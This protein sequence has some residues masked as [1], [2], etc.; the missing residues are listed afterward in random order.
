[1]GQNFLPCDREQQLLMP[2]SLREWLPEGHLAWFVLDAVEELDLAAFY[3]GYRLDGHG[4]AALDPQMMVALVLYAYAVGERSARG[5]ER[6]CREDVAFRVIAANQTPDH[7]TVARFRVRHEQALG[8][9]FGSVLALCAR[10]GLVRAG[11]VALDGTKIAANA[12]GQASMDY[13]QIAREIVEE[14]A[15]V[16]REEDERFGAARG[17]ELP[18]E[19][20]DPATRK[21]RLRQAKRELEAEWEA[22][23]EAAEA[24]NQRCQEHAEARAAGRAKSGRPPLPRPLPERPGGRVNVTDPDSRPVKTHRGFIQ[25]YN[26][27]AAATEDQIVVAAEVM[28]GGTD[29]GLL[30]PMAARIAEELEQA[31]IDEPIGTLLADAGYWNREQIQALRQAGTDT[32]VTPD[33]RKRQRP[34]KQPLVREL[35]A[36]LETDEGRAL[37]RKRAQTIEPVFGQTKTNRRIDRFQRRGLAACRSEWRLIT[38]THNLLK[39][40]RYGAA[41]ATA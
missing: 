24:H 36:R 17:D 25:G 41:P 27:Q 28:I 13:E 10:A 9:L 20:A 11:T 22:E 35:R 4:R 5:V 2:P 29:Q 15:R 38:A 19:L 37:Y 3:A 32:L 39:L 12:S 14:S 23:R 18:P 33:G 40:W 1:M 16:D 34:L 31:G 26:A 21:A 8:G 6:R 30:A 7:A